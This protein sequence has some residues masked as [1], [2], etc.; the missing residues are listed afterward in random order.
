MDL[1]S[2]GV[3][4]SN[5]KADVA[6]VAVVGA[7]PAGSAVA[8][9]LARAGHSVLL[10]DRAEKKEQKPGETLPP[11]ANQVLRSLGVW[12][13]FRAQ[14]HLPAEGILSVWVDRNPRI[15]DFFLSPSGPGWNL[16]RNRFDAMLV[17]ECRKAGV[18]VLRAAGI[19][20]C[21]RAKQR[22]WELALSEK[23]CTRRVFA[24]YLVDATGR[25]GA[26][27]LRLLSR[28]TVLDRMIAV[29]RIVQCA[30]RSR[31]TLI[32]AVDEGWFY[33]AGLPGGRMVVMYFTD[34]DI[35]SHR[36]R[37][38][39]DYWGTQC[40]KAEHTPRRLRGALP[41][42]PLR[43]VSAATSRR[44]E[45]QGEGWIAVG[46]AAYC[47]D[48]LSSLGIYKA[49]DSAMRACNTITGLFYGRQ[50]DG[51]YQDWSDDVFRHYLRHRTHFYKR[52]ELFSESPFWKRRQEILP[53][54]G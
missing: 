33:S 39:S 21:V 17:E 51:G 16:D 23:R 38:S 26:P 18:A 53:S 2:A 36:S 1:S 20:S 43:I 42:G 28:R 41:C 30:D 45:V 24:R 7:G 3:L 12:D 47:F 52:E 32:E 5:W 35:Y 49:L 34:S 8:L 14:G 22:G 9:L 27:A 25:T 4:N 29:V 19:N 37:S 6:D 40:A 10:L 46:D 48:P 54:G 15:N 13:I 31:Y 50:P 44:A 11:V